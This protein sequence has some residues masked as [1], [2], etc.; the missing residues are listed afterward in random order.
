MNHLPEDIKF[1][2]SVPVGYKSYRLVVQGNVAWAISTSD[3]KGTFEERPVNSAG[4]ELMVL[5]RESGGWRIRTIHW[6]SR[7]R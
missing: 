4:V 3:M 2:K 7:R 6:S 1:E 5:S